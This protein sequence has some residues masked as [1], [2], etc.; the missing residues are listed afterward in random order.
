MEAVIRTARVDELEM[1]MGRMDGERIELHGTPV[2]VAEQ[3]GKIVGM[4]AARLVWQVEP[5]TVF[6]EV[7]NEMTRRRVTRELY[8]AAASWLG[9]RDRN[10][11]GIYTAFAV[12]RSAAV[13]GW[14]KAMGWLEQYRGATLF[15]KR[16]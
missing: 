5:M 16:F 3:D 14:S 2:W 13:L 15:T 10:A 1:L 4:I 12:T 8:R 9:D 6:P 11:T 7:T